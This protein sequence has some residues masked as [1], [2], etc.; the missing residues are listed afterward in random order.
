M[1]HSSYLY[2]RDQTYYFR[3]RIPRDLKEYF[4]GSE[5]FKRTLRTKCLSIARKL[6]KS[7]SAKTEETFMMMRS[8]LLRLNLLMR[9]QIGWEGHTTG[10]NILLNARK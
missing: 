2:Q 6:L 7:W 5:D 10:H 3:C 9:Y 8:G 1:A 4:R